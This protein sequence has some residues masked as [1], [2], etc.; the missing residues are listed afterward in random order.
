MSIDIINKFCQIVS[1][2]FL[3]PDPKH[4]AILNAA[5]DAVSAYGYRKTSMDDIAKGAG[6]SRPALY[7][8]FKN[9]EA[10]CRSLVARYF[11]NAICDV[12]E[13]LN[14]DGALEKRLLNAFLAQGGALAE[15][16]FTSA[17]GREILDVSTAT[18]ADLVAD[19]EL[20][21][22]GVYA[23]WLEEQSAAGAIKLLA[24]PDPTAKA[25]V[26]ALHG[27]K[28]SS[29]DFAEY[30]QQIDV[31]AKMTAAALSV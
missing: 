7:V 12:H 26:A 13:A 3:P 5:W 16:L 18:C 20:E 2:R 6:M 15:T 27:I 11:Y 14:A 23:R 24:K 4:D 1:M 30:Q 17:H 22:T 8:H 29:G 31:F 10:I 28:S 21:L 19:G 9:K 25:L